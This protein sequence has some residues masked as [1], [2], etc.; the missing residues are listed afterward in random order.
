MSWAAHNPELFY[1]M[2]KRGICAKIGSSLAEYGFSFPADTSDDR[3]DYLRAVVEVLY[4][5]PNPLASSLV[6]W[7][8]KEIGEEERD[9]FSGMAP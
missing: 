6:A 1:K 4:D 2:C 7:A 9:H 5:A 8:A 3:D